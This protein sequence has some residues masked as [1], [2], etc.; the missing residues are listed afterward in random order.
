MF[1]LRCMSRL[2]VVVGLM[3]SVMTPTVVATGQAAALAAEDG[4]HDQVVA[5]GAV[6]AWRLDES[7]GPNAVD[8]LG[9]NDAPY[10]GSPVFSEPPLTTDGGSA[11]RFDGAGATIHLVNSLDINQGG[12]FPARSVELWFTA[13]SVGPRQTLY[14]QGSIARGLNLFIENGKLNAGVFNTDTF[15]G[16]TAWGPVFVSTDIAANATYHTVM[17]FDSADGMLRLF[18][19]GVEA[20]SAAGVGELYAHGRSAIGSQWHWSRYPDGANEGN[21][22][23]FAGTIDNVALY[24]AALSPTRISDHYAAG[25]AA[26]SGAPQLTIV[27]PSAGDVVAG[28]IV[29][30]ITTTDD[31]PPGTLT[32]ETSIAGG[33]WSSA[34]WNAATGRYETSWDTTSVADGLVTI[35]ARSTDSDGNTSNASRQVTVRNGS[36]TDYEDAIAAD[37]AVVLWRLGEIAGNTATD[38]IG[39][40]DAAILGNPAL[41][42]TGL[43]SAADRAMGFDGTDDTIHLTNSTDV[44]Q[45]GPFTERSFELWFRADTTS[46][47]QTLYE[48]GSVSRGMSLYI[49]GGLLYAGIYN[50][51]DLGGATPWGP[52]FVSTPVASGVTYHIV[53]TFDEAADQWRLFVNGALAAA[54]GGLGDLHSHG[55]SAIGSQWHWARYHDGAQEGDINHFAGV[56]DEVALYP[57]AL[58]SS[59][60]A[61]HYISGAAAGPIVPDVTIESPPAGAWISGNR[62]VAIAAT[63]DDALGSLSVDLSVDGAATWLAAPWNSSTNRYELIWNTTSHPDGPATLLARALDSDGHSSVSAAHQVTISNAAPATSRRQQKCWQRANAAQSDLALSAA[64]KQW[65]LD[66]CAGDAAAEAV[67]EPQGALAPEIFPDHLYL[68]NAPTEIA[69]R[70]GHALHC[71]D[72]SATRFGLVWAPG[73]NSGNIDLDAA[74]GS[75]PINYMGEYMIAEIGGQVRLFNRVVVWDVRSDSQPVT[76]KHQVLS[77]SGSP[78]STVARIYGLQEFQ[79]ISVWTEIPATILTAYEADIPSDVHDFIIPGKVMNLRTWYDD[80]YCHDKRAE[81]RIPQLVLDYATAHGFG[82]GSGSVDEP[83]RIRLVASGDPYTAASWGL[84]I[85]SLQIGNAQQTNGYRWFYD[86]NVTPTGAAA[87]AE[88]DS[89]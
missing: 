76:I 68:M 65:L 64:Q 69:D 8:A 73:A 41:G 85:A 31:D 46:G 57:H 63:D 77:P 7:T 37:G 86:S 58:S 87:L 53:A 15:G 48:Q 20:A 32:T 62:V 88:I 22:H 50:T 21:I 43:I 55:R 16:G 81:T 49:D 42:V 26:A 34:S 67:A 78:N 2:G 82:G 83:T 60:V 29:V 74:G 54:A 61:A 6:V 79:P 13:D 35:D 66:R 30:G 38:A 80:T 56:I 23:F 75:A 9:G 59:Q 51:E 14:E 33:P 44:N 5:D 52:V 17:T 24:A 10:Q 45:G 12:P 40:N 27:T 18:V 72:I 19:N 70:F 3:A 36:P 71:M 4:Y 11:V 47:R 84:N 89:E 25:T 28:T 39:G 1:G